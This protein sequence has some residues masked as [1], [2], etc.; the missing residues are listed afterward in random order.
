VTDIALIF[1]GVVAA[2]AVAAIT[3]GG[4]S[5]KHARRQA[6]L[7]SRQHHDLQAPAWDKPE[8]AE[9]GASYT[10][11]LPLLSDTFLDSVRL[12]IL[13]D[14]CQTAGVVLEGGDEGAPTGLD[15]GEAATWRVRVDPQGHPTT[16]ARV[17]ATAGN[18]DW[19]VLIELPFSTYQ[20]HDVTTI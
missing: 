9:S 14:H 16:K 2:G 6:R 3:Y 5:I 20:W 4:I 13:V 1:S 10:L 7:A 17:T 12:Q 15:Q 18:H 8:L 19:S 11:S